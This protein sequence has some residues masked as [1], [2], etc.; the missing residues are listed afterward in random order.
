[1]SSSEPAQLQNSDLRYDEYRRLSELLHQANRLRDCGRTGEAAELYREAIRWIG[2]IPQEAAMA[3]FLANVYTNLGIAL[4]GSNE[5]LRQAI[6]CFDRAISLRTPLLDSE[7]PWILYGLCAGWMN[8]ADAFTKLGGARNLTAAVSSYDTALV[9]L[10]ELPL[11][12][13]PQFPRRVAIAWI[14]RGHTLEKLL[15]PKAAESFQKAIEV[16]TLHRCGDDQ[17]ILMAGAHANMANALAALERPLA[18]QVISSARLSLGL[19]SAIENINVHAAEIGLKARH[20]L[21]RGIAIHLDS[22]AD[23]S[24]DNLVSEATD[25]VEHGIELARRFATT[26]THSLQQLACELFAFGCRV[27]QSCQPQFLAEY[28]L[29]HLDSEDAGMRTAASDSLWRALRRAR[30]DAFELLNTAQFPKVADQLRK[31]CHAQSRLA[32][33]ALAA[34]A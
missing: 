6:D 29:D 11:G 30:N 23:P 18:N 15:S 12:L 5:E 28:I 22:I 10:D 3:N 32:E 16:L 8:R 2:P 27:Y 33:P 4:L 20:A 24:A 14:N 26:E 25:A 34:T 21:C 13:D 19:V 17:D 31:L 1:M 9:L 7:E